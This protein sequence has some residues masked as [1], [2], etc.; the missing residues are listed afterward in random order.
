MI[1]LRGF[2]I[3]THFGS[4]AKYINIYTY[5]LTQILHTIVNTNAK[6]LSTEYLTEFFC[7]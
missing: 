2:I 5:I 3:S 6:A 7:G 1:S 4:F